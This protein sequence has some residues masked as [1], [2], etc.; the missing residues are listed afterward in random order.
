V[1]R[2][3]RRG[4]DP[5][6]RSPGHLHGRCGPYTP[7]FLAGYLL[8]GSAYRARHWPGARGVGRL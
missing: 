1:T 8:S 7:D 4:E 3:E 5:I 6:L 2:V